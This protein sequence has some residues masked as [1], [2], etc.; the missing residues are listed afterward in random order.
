MGDLSFT[1]VDQWEVIHQLRAMPPPDGGR[2]LNS[3]IH[4]QHLPTT[5]EPTVEAAIAKLLR[6]HVGTNECWLAI[7]GASHLGKSTAVTQVLLERAMAEPDRWRTRTASGHLQTPYVYIEVTSSMEARGILAAVAKAIG[8]PDTGTEKQLHDSLS[9]SLPD[10]GVLL[11]VVDDAQML[12]RVS[13][14][15]SRLVDGLRHLLHLPVPFAYVG[16]DLE[17]SALLRDPGRNNDTVLQLQ[18]RAIQTRLAPISSRSGVKDIVAIARGF[19]RQMHP[20]TG[21]DTRCL[22]DARLL[23]AVANQIEGRP[24][25]FINTL[26]R[27]SI[28]ALALNHGVL[29]ADLVLAEA[30]AV[31]QWVQEVSEAA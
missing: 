26:K 30:K 1:R 23:L 8:L 15:A 5:Y 10:L 24:G 25:S 19:A 28:E 31:Q 9:K 7:G 18:R 6:H 21:L 14:N 16:I 27:A 29:T 4:A 20:V 22:K 13:D 2:A 3:W 11:I 17:R 12:R